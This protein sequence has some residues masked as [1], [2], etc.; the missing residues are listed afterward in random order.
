MEKYL[1]S[2]KKQDWLYTIIL[3]VFVVAFLFTR[4]YMLYNTTVWYDE[5]VSLIFAKL[6]LKEII[7]QSIYEQNTPFYYF[8][9]HFWYLLFGNNILVLRLSSLIISSLSLLFLYL[10]TSKITNKW[11]ALISI[12]LVYISPLQTI[13]SVELRSYG[14]IMLLSLLNLYSLWMLLTLKK[15]KIVSWEIIYVVSAVLGLLFHLTF[16]VYLF[17]QTLIYFIY[18]AVSF[19]NTK[20][21]NLVVKKQLYKRLILIFSPWVITAIIILVCNLAG[22]P[23]YVS[24][25][26][27]IIKNSF[28]LHSTKDLLA[29]DPILKTTGLFLVYDQVSI[30]FILFAV[31]IYGFLQIYEK[32]T[33]FTTILFSNMLVTLIVLGSSAKGGSRYIVFIF[34]IMVVGFCVG[35][36]QLYK[37]LLAVNKSSYLKINKLLWKLLSLPVLFGSLLL[38]AK[39]VFLPVN[40]GACFEEIFQII[41]QKNLPKSALLLNGSHF[42]DVANYYNFQDVIDVKGVDLIYDPLG[43][44]LSFPLRIKNNWRLSTSQETLP[45]LNNYIK[46]YDY[47]YYADF[48][49]LLDPYETIPQWLINN[50]TLFHKYSLTCLMDFKQAQPLYLFK[51]E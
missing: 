26:T 37:N 41:Q 45:N 34:P 23:L 29:Q 32:H 14:L 7:K 13:L 4:I 47:V 42:E 30:S 31:A 9:L 16:L 12:V 6:S 15:S 10:L 22:F 24:Q 18:L 3:S 48:A 38:P 49:K 25:I 11:G 21:T 33:M 28:S 1:S 46:N 19:K 2:F 27:Q 35:V 44:G 8:F 40:Y 39:Y 17:A 5:A 43:V 50:T 36:I 20:P 51:V